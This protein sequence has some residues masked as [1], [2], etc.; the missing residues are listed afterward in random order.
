MLLIYPIHKQLL[1][2]F[3]SILAYTANDILYKL[4]ANDILYKLY[5]KI[6]VQYLVKEIMYDHVIKRLYTHVYTHKA[7]VPQGQ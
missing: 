6:V 7:L 3:P 4:I 1:W 5:T 2:G